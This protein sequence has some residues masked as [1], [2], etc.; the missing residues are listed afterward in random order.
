MEAQKE[1]IVTSEQV[2]QLKAGDIV[3]VK[4]VYGGRTYLDGDGVVQYVIGEDI[5]TSS[6]SYEHYFSG[7]FHFSNVTLVKSQNQSDILDKIKQKLIELLQ[8]IG[9]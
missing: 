3:H 8:L 7:M 4:M 6:I 9:G 2:K 5:Q 1:F